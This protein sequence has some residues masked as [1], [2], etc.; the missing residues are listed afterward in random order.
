[1]VGGCPWLL[2]SAPWPC[3]SGPQVPALSLMLA[4]PV[5]LAEPWP[6]TPSGTAQ[7]APCPAAGSL[8]PWPDQA[9]RRSLAWKWGQDRVSARRPDSPGKS[10][11]SAE[12]VPREP[13]EL[14][15]PGQSRLPG[16]GAT[17]RTPTAWWQE[18]WARSWAAWPCFY[19]WGGRGMVQDCH[20]EPRS[21]P[22]SPPSLI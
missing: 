14:G 16:A 13:A 10:P 4:A 20:S 12:P 3:S 22:S 2:V 21:I 5:G 1:M 8:G 18:G 11:M 19:S 6:T 17:N 15:S 7:T 9:G